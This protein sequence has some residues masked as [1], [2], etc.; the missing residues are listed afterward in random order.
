ML[1]ARVVRLLLVMSRE[2]K[3]NHSKMFGSRP[4]FFLRFSCIRVDRLSYES[5]PIDKREQNDWRAEKNLNGYLSNQSIEKLIYSKNSSSVLDKVQ[6][7]S[8][9]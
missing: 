9:T 7:K 4:I 8:E 6:L 3:E 5:K 2:R 1:L